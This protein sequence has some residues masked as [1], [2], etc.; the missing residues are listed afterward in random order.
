MRTH[1]TK[2]SLGT[3]IAVL[4]T[5]WCIG[6]FF[7]YA[8]SR[9]GSDAPDLFGLFGLFILD[10][11]AASMGFAFYVVLSEKLPAKSQAEIR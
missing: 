3:I 1:L 10:A 11:F 6:T 5:L 2:D 4:V 8:K 9:F 7:I